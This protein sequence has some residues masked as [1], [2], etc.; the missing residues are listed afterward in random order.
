MRLI[1]LFSFIVILNSG[2][3]GQEKVSQK[4]FEEITLVNKI[5]FLNSKFDQSRFSCGF[6]LQYNNDTFAVTAKHLLK[7]IKPD[8]MKTLSFEN[9]IKSWSLYPLTKKDEVVVTDKLLNQNKSE[10]LEKKSTY[11]NDWLI[12]SLKENRS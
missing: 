5:E 9:I 6:L 2:C 12:F 11:D 8:E 4:I 10:L 3:S 1:Y 7:I